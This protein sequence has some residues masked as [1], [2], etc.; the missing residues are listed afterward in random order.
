MISQVEL[1]KEI[2]PH[3]MTASR[4]PASGDGIVLANQNEK[5]PTGEYGAI[6]FSMHS[7]RHGQGIIQRNVNEADKTISTHYKQ[8]VRVNAPVEFYRGNA[9]VYANNLHGVNRISEIRWA[10]LRK[11]IAIAGAGNV[12]DLTA[13]QSGNY[14]QRSRI[15]L[16]LWLDINHEYVV[17]QILAVPYSVQYEGNDIIVS[18]LV[19]KRN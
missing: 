5:A 7:Q 1:F 4:L 18:G 2:R 11:G 8:W 12:L 3:L 17:N 14:E 9:M 6:Q 13:L 10:L 19:D 15:E 16:E